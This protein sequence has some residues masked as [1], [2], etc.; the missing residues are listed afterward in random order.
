M[1]SRIPIARHALPTERR[2]RRSREDSHCRATPTSWIRIIGRKGNKDV[3]DDVDPL[4][5]IDQISRMKKVV[6][7]TARRANERE[8]FISHDAFHPFKLPIEKIRHQSH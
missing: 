6:T 4:T 8:E 3:R 1:D 7:P 2:S 5:L